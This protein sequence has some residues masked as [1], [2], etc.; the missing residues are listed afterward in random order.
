MVTFCSFSIK[1]N[2]NRQAVKVKEAREVKLVPL[3]SQRKPLNQDLLRLV[4]K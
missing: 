1:L 4:F 3:E 2:L